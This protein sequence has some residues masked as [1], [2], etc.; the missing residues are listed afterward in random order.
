MKTKSAVVNV[1]LKKENDFRWHAN[2]VYSLR[3]KQ[4]LIGGGLLDRVSLPHNIDLWVNDEMTSEHGLNLIILWDNKPDYHQYIF[5]P[6]L[7]SGVDENGETVSLTVF[8]R[9]WIAKQ[10]R[11]GNLTNGQRITVIDVNVGGAIV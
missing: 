1:L 2:S 7:L 3:D 4:E 10:L 8:Q 5:G 9:K 11:I 6:V